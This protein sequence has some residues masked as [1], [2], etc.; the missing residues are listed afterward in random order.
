MHT[1]E[2]KPGPDK[3]QIEQYHISDALQYYIA[4]ETHCTHLVWNTWHVNWTRY[5]L[6]HV[7][8]I[9]MC[10]TYASLFNPPNGCYYYYEWEMCG[11]IWWNKPAEWPLLNHFIYRFYSMQLFWKA[12]ECEVQSTSPIKSSLQT[13]KSL[14][15]QSNEHETIIASRHFFAFMFHICICSGNMFMFSVIVNI[16]LLSWFPDKTLALYEKQMNWLESNA[17]ATNHWNAYTNILLCKR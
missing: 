3:W 5:T 9:A 11:Y 1:R 15:L 2:R 12:F 8:F 17:Y 14:N 4:R 16:I 6:V 7:F 10:Y 13:G